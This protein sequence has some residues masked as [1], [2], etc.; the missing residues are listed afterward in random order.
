[1]AAFPAFF[2]EYSQAPGDGCSCCSGSQGPGV[3]QSAVVRRW[4]KAGAIDFKVDR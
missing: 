2:F 3:N 4:N 1:M